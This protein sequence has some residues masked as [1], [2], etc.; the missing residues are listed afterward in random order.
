[1]CAQSA[2]QEDPPV[3][4]TPPVR[5]RMP[6]RGGSVGALPG[7]RPRVGFID[8]KA[9]MVDLNGLVRSPHAG[10][11]AALADEA[12]FARVFVEHGVV[13]WPGEIDLA[14]DAMYAEIRKSGEWVLR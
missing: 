13:T 11:F 9:G 3:A 14:P 8:G 1:M 2:A 10:V 4:V 5:P 7:D 12:Q 6:W